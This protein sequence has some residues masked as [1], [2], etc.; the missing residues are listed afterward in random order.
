MLPVEAKVGSM[1][2]ST[3]C[4]APGRSLMMYLVVAASAEKA[5][6]RVATRIEAENF[7]RI[8]FDRYNK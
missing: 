3:C 5:T 4:E 8:E 7:I 6:K 2:R 1:L